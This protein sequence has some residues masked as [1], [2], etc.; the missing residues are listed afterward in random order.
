MK[1]TQIAVAVCAVFAA[2]S[3]F[4]DFGDANVIFNENGELVEKN[5]TE[6]KITE[7]L[8]IKAEW[9]HGLWNSLQEARVG[10]MI[11]PNNDGSKSYV[12]NAGGTLSIGTLTLKVGQDNPAQVT[13]GSLEFYP[14]KANTVDSTNKTIEVN[15]VILEANSSLRV[16][17]SNDSN[18]AEGQNGNGKFIKGNTSVRFGEV[19]M[20]E[21]TALAFSAGE[22][23][24]KINKSDTENKIGMPDSIIIDHI[25]VN[26]VAEIVSGYQA[27]KQAVI[28]VGSIDINKGDFSF[29]TPCSSAGMAYDND[30]DS[31]SY[32]SMAVALIALNKSI[33]INMNTENSVLSL[34]HLGT[35]TTPTALDIYFNE[36]ALGSD[37]CQVQVFTDDFTKISN[38]SSL[39]VIAADGI[40]S[41]ST[42]LGTAQKLADKV[43]YNNSN[44]ATGTD[45]DRTQVLGPLAERKATVVAAG[46]DEGYTYDIDESGQIIPSSVVVTENTTTHAF[47]QLSAVN[48][49]QW[50]S[51][52]NHLQYRMGELRDH[53]GLNNGAWIRAYNG[54]D[55]YGSQ[56]VKNTYYGFQAGYDHRLEG[57]N[58]LVGGAVSYAHGDSDFRVGDGNNYNYHFTGYGTWLADNGLFL[59]GTF[60]VGRLSNDVTMNALSTAGAGKAS[61]ET[62][63]FSVSAE[64]GWRFNWQERASIEQQ[65]EIMYGR[66]NSADYTFRDISVTAESVESTVGRLGLQTGF[67]CPS[68][69]GGA[70]LRAS[71]LH[72]FQ[73]TTRTRFARASRSTTIS[74]DLGDTWY[75]LGIGANYN[76]TDTTYFYADVNYAAG[77]EVE[78]PWRW[79]IGVRHAF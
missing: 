14:E 15:T 61:Y 77:G 9:N 66:I 71:V 26:G 57:T 63:A 17:K 39:Q 2:G 23:H 78:S 6:K 3:A 72:D 42:P 75:E 18:T 73:G 35:E 24:Q 48:Y 46:I 79:S 27:S 54:K 65:A 60:K 67:T 56:D 19:T 50:R 25:T 34:G 20:A 36:E 43:F 76:L 30:P 13:K 52:M 53:S 64:L 37:T 55:K 59:D 47:S 32:T 70:Y 29:G 33:R 58:I 74:E 62:N 7:P 4:A 1:A 28:Q 41:G 40:L 68:K 45:Q 51:A 5:D 44:E 16:M 38:G 12:K 10:T 8:E 21:N 22:A 49:M 11:M 69:K 31:G